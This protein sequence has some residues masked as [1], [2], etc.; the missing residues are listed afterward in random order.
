MKEYDVMRPGADGMCNCGVS[1]NG[2]GMEGV[3]S[4]RRGWALNIR[5]LKM[6]AE[7]DR[8]TRSP[9]SRRLG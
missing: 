7:A 4:L 9:P 3:A 1:V 2:R 6:T 8:E 5:N